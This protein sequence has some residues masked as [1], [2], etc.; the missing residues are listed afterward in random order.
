MKF[1][2][3]HKSEEVS[4][5]CQDEQLFNWSESHLESLLTELRPARA[6]RSQLL[7]LDLTSHWLRRHVAIGDSCVWP[8][9]TSS[10]KP[11][12]WSQ[13]CSFFVFQYRQCWRNWYHCGSGFFNPNMSCRWSLL[14]GITVKRCRQTLTS[15]RR[16]G[17]RVWKFKVFKQLSRAGNISCHMGGWVDG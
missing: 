14:I 10:K 11:V 17:V 3:C 12:A 8:K 6:R 2:Q 1:L 9:A 16:S 13:T 15:Q 4:G 5:M 7:V